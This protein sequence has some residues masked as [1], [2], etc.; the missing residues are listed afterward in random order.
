MKGGVVEGESSI[1]P[2]IYVAVLNHIIEELKKINPDIN[3]NKDIEKIITEIKTLI[4]NKEN[5]I[6]IF[7]NAT[8]KLLKVKFKITV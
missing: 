2:E 4:P 3:N 8:Q 6:E 5:T 1:D 7:N